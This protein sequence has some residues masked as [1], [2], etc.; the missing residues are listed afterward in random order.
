MIKFFRKIRQ[1][2]LIENKTSK[3]LAYA[4][5]EIALVMIGILLALQ[6][7]NWNENKKSIAQEKIILSSLLKD[8]ET[9]SNNLQFSLR[10]YNNADLQLER[11][12]NYIGRNADAFDQETKDD[13]L[14][15]IV[16]FPKLVNGTLN[17]L[18][19]SD[20]LGLI[21]NDT[22][23]YWLT[24]YAFDIDANLALTEQYRVM[25]A[26]E[27]RP[28]L[29]SYVSL[30]DF[31]SNKKEYPEAST[32]ARPSDYNGLLNDTRFQNLLIRE[33]QHVNRY[34]NVTNEFLNR[35]NY[36]IDL[37]RVALELPIVLERL[38]NSEKTIDEVVEI[39][40]QQDINEPV[41][42]I[43][44]NS[45]IDLGYKLM[46]EN[47]NNKAL[48]LFKLSTELYPDAWNTHDS[49]G[50]CLLQLGDKE[51]AIKAYEKSLELNPDN[52]YAKE[53]L[54]ELK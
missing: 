24:T 47:E 46:E 17:S 44:E 12:L 6:V 36:I 43:S 31:S 50:E 8:F 19:S 41:Y 48:K 42:D 23:K 49:Y 32:N 21:Q 25:L 29:D 54:S 1:N 4:F 9:N 51:N 20:Q 7:N 16:M 13:I 30:L 45:I 40:K 53:A 10:L 35:T 33:K 5:G 22:L 3:Y 2:L 38:L 14:A 15:S 34:I 11:R 28:L 37:I 18:L 26:E 27:H 52:Q 39:M